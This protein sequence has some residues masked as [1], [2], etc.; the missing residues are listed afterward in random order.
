MKET[1]SRDNISVRWDWALNK[2]RVA[3]FYFPKDDA[4]VRV[5][6]GDELR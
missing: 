2:K 6:A 3:Y 1:H 5:L 4:D